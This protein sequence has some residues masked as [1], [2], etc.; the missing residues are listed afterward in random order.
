MA[1][2]RSLLAIL[3]L[4]ASLHALLIAQTLLPAQDGLKLIR[5]A[6]QFQTDPWCDVI[7]NADVHP[8]YPALVAAIEPL[9]AWFAGENPD[10]WRISAQLVAAMASV[11]L[12]VPVYFLTER[13]FDRRIAFVAAGVLALLPR[14]AEAGHETLAD[15]LALFATFTALCLGGRALSSGNRR[16]ALGSGL[17]SGLGYLARPEVLLVPFVIALAALSQWR[18]EAGPS[19][20]RRILAVVV[21]LAVPAMATGGYTAVKG[22]ITEKLALRSGAWLGP[23]RILIRPVPQQLPRGLEDPRWD[24]SPKEETDRIVIRGTRQALSRIVV[25]WWEETAWFF[26]VMTAWGMARRKEILRL[27]HQGPERE[28]VDGGASQELRLLD[29][30]GSSQHRHDGLLLG[31]FAGVYALALLRHSTTLG[32]L[33]WRHVLPLVVAS[34]PWAA[35]G[36]YLCCRRTGELLRLGPGGFRVARLSAMAFT[37]LL[38]ISVQMNPNHLNHLSRWGHWA[39]GR[40]LS[41]HAQPGE[42][43]LDTRGWARFVSERPGYDYWHV[44]Q[45]LTDSNLSYVLVG[46]D[47]LEARSPRAATL[48]ALL[49]YAATPL[50]DFPDSPGGRNPAVRIYR[51]QHPDSWEGLAR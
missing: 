2:R 43:T 7:R 49:A 45:A 16:L 18:R 20:V 13:L 36:T 22:Q 29:G 14:V 27:I 25:R 50:A 51:F 37:L 48:R 46:L 9:A 3:L 24:F 10:A 35:A 40:W 28:Q 44:R 33:S 11:A 21:M 47:E 34:I 39:A 8:L 4:A 1:R 30:R 23:Q 12:L 26:A 32:Y 41:E 5:F 19:R 38:S 42:Q 17:A 6:R 15:S 31:L